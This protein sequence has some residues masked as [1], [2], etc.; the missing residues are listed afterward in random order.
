MYICG[1]IPQNFAELTK[2]VPIDI[3]CD[4]SVVKPHFQNSK[5]M[6]S[7]AVMKST[8]LKGP[9]QFHLKMLST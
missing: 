9:A 4:S 6:F 3:L 1:L 5:Y 7:V 2:A 8:I